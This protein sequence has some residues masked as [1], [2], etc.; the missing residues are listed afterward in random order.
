MKT[1]PE[2]DRKNRR[3]VL[4]HDIGH[5]RLAEPPD[6]RRVVTARRES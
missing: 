1:S 2:W 5:R 3:R 6:A 4:E